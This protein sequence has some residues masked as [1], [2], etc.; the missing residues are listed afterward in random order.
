MTTYRQIDEPSPTIVGPRPAEGAGGRMQIPQGLERLLTLAG[1]SA[2]WREK[3]L[4]DP[5]A[6]AAEASIELAASERAILE[7]VPRPAL[8]AMAGSFARRHGGASFGKLAAGAAAAALLAGSAFAGEIPA[9]PGGIRADEPP[10]QPAREGVPAPTGIRPDVPE[11]AP[12]VLWMTSLDDALAQAKKASRAVMA[13]F[14]HP[15][16]PAGRENSRRDVII[17]GAMAY[18]PT[19]EEKSQQVVLT[20]SKE[21]RVAV[22]NADLIAVKVARPAKPRDLQADNTAEQLAQFEAEHQAYEKASQAYAAAFKKYGLSEKKLPAVIF[23]APD[24]SELSKLVQPDEEKIFTGVIKDV[25]PLL[26]GWL[27]AQRKPKT[28]PGAAG[29]IRSDMPTPVGSRPAPPEETE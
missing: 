2:E 6:A 1:I 12:A 20:D 7:S 22:R 18:M 25:P 29:G 5:G 8:A 17:A 16:P 13:V 14:P 9:A 15:N 28:T 19:L 23:L 24:G 27:T 10:P 11:E 4:A 26:A 21:F 3:V